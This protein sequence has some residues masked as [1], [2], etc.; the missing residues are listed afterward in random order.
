MRHSYRSS[1]A[2][3][4]LPLALAV[5]GCG[6]ESR[7]T[8]PVTDT[9]MAA[10][11]TRTAAPDTTAERLWAYLE[12]AD[13]KTWP[14][15]PG[16]TAHYAGTEPHGALLT[17]YVNTLALDAITNGAGMMPVGTILVKENY[18]PDS[19]LAAVTVLYKSAG[20]D[21]AHHDWFWMKRLANGT[22][23]ASGRV[24]MCISCH[25]GKEGNDYIMTAALK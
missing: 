22:V 11:S 12:S 9:A 10:A 6:G 17:T 8:P 24:A 3:F 19:T 25:G 4:A 1:V 2:V 15:W 18:M 21:G 23:E 16:K 14:M 5:L 13:Y 20:Y 7:E